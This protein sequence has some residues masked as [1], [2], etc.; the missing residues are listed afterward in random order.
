M[1][2]KFQVL[3][4]GLESFQPSMEMM[5]IPFER[6]EV[7]QLVPLGLMNILYEAQSLNLLFMHLSPHVHKHIHNFV[8]LSFNEIKG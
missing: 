1:H 3:D 6:C 8:N 2:M 5:L 4:S 7:I